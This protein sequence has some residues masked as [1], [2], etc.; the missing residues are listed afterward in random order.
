MRIGSSNIEQTGSSGVGSVGGAPTDSRS[1]GASGS[2]SDSVNLTS[3]SNLIALAKASPVSQL[4]KI[5]AL[6]AEIKSGTYQPDT[7][8][9]GRAVV[10]DHIAG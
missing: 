3:F 10:A 4:S 2:K 8:E 9:V 1:S 5:Q 7:V 6:S